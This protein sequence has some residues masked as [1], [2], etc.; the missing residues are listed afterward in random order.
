VDAGE[1]PEGFG[2]VLGFCSGCGPALGVGTGVVNAATICGDGCS[3]GVGEVTG[4]G[5]AAFCNFGFAA[6][7][8]TDVS[9]VKHPTAIKGLPIETNF[10]IGILV[11]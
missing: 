5:S 11:L 3:P 8:P 10:L 6:S 7:H 9:R 1:G 4:V 2:N